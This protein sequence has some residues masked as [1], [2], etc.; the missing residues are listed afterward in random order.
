MFFASLCVCVAKLFCLS[1]FLLNFYF[2]KF[3]FNYGV[4]ALVVPNLFG[5]LSSFVESAF[6][7]AL[8]KAFKN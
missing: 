4:L 2:A 7:N 6:A 8:K 1:A 3:G 5:L